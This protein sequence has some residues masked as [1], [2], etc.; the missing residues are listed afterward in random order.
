MLAMMGHMSRP[1]LERESHVRMTAKR[2]AVAGATLS[3]RG[4][5]SELLP[6]KV[7]V[8]AGSIPSQ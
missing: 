1:T 7:P 2:D 6:V 3:P 5:N 8:L 4:E